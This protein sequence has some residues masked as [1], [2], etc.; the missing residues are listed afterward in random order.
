M[1]FPARGGG[2]MSDFTAFVPCGINGVFSARGGC[3]DCEASTLSLMT[4]EGLVDVAISSWCE[5]SESSSAI[6]ISGSILLFV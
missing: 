3:W 2:P 1:F 4:H 5:F 6:S